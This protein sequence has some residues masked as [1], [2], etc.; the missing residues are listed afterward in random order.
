[1]R[2]FSFQW[3]VLVTGLFIGVC[4]AFSFFR[5]SPIIPTLI[6]VFHFDIVIAGLLMAIFAI[7]VATL[8]IPIGLM[9]IKYDARKICMIALLLIMA[10]AIVGVLATN[11]ESLLLGRL[12][13]GAGLAFIM[14]ATPAFVMRWFPPEKGGTVMAV[15]A[16]FFPLGTITGLNISAIVMIAY[17]WKVAWLTSFIFSLIG[18]ILIILLR[19][20]PEPLAKLTRNNER[21]TS[22]REL[23]ANLDLWLIA[24]TFLLAQ[25]VVAAFLTLGPTYLVEA[26]NL[27]IV[28][29]SF[30]VSLFM[31][32]G[33]LGTGMGGIISDRIW[34][35]KRVYI[36]ALLISLILYP[37]LMFSTGLTITI[38]IIIWGFA[39][40]FAPPALFACASDILGPRA[41]GLGLGIINSA[42][43]ASMAIGPLLFVSLYE[44][45]GS[46]DIALLFFLPLSIAAV[47]VGLLP[48]NVK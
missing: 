45:M 15:W 30:A 28:Y 13:E 4:G 44:S 46:W 40:S 25:I 7:A 21:T 9:A 35:R 10:G 3:I 34:S 26:R 6:N 39:F 36:P 16:N 5:A 18:L 1:M 42:I 27:T 14:T 19:R 24:L 37:S 11:I 8:S 23:I 33:I 32:F 41:A 17:G 20:E 12:L 38:M 29:A 48:K 31:I 22:T 43:G 2:K 47:I